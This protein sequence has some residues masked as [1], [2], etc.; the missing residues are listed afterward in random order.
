MMMMMM[1]PVPKLLFHTYV[2][3]PRLLF[4]LEQLR[5]GG[6]QQRQTQRSKSKKA[7]NSD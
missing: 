2:P 6:Q 7:A 1:V 3:F 4:P 5:E